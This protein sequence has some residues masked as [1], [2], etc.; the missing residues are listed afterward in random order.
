V[1][2]QFTVIL[3]KWLSVNDTVS[4]MDLWQHFKYKKLTMHGEIYY[5]SFHRKQMSICDDGFCK[6]EA[7]N[8]MA[9][10]C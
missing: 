5:V 8:A 4:T 3:K 6:I 10:A 7:I 1:K 2:F 9:C